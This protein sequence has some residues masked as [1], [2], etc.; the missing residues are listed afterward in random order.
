M[1]HQLSRGHWDGTG[2]HWHKHNPG[3]GLFFSRLLYSTDRHARRP[4]LRSPLSLYSTYSTPQTDREGLE[5]PRTKRPDEAACPHAQDWPTFEDGR[6]RS[7]EHPLRSMYT[8]LR[9]PSHTYSCCLGQGMEDR[10]DLLVYITQ[11]F[12][13]WAH[14]SRC[15]MRRL[16]PGGV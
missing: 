4:Q 9:N 15:S 6:Q 12:V 7:R 13:S 3:S 2:A 8:L 1:R 14:P 10:N 5:T 11:Q 16:A